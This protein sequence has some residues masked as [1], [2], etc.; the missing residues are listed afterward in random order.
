MNRR[1]HWTNDQLF[2]RLLNN[3]SDKTYWDNIIEL[4]KRGSEDIFTRCSHMATTGD[5][6]EREIAM[7]VLAQLGSAPRPFYNQTITLCFDLL[8][9]EKHPEVLSAILYAIGHNNQ[10]LDA[11]QISS[12]AL[13]KC[14]PDKSIRSGVVYALLGVDK[15]EAIN[16]LIELSADKVADI[17]NWATFGIGSQIEKTSEE[18][19]DA[20]W[21]RINDKDEDTRLEAISGLAIRKDPRV[22]DMP[23]PGQLTDLL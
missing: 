15:E 9:T 4:R 22:K 8:Q 1:K 21:N 20:L 12:I 18:I 11:R 23:D 13:F 19:I 7:D 16:I 14:H 10:H 5:D 17:R 2:T 3:K 6:I